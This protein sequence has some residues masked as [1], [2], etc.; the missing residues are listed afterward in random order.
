MI[1]QMALAV[2]SYQ[3]ANCW[4]IYPYCSGKLKYVVLHMAHYNG[5][6]EEK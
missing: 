1:I 5:S 3:A 2:N 4:G 6:G